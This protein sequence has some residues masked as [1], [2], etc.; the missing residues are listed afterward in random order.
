MMKR[1][2]WGKLNKKKGKIDFDEDDKGKIVI[3]EDGK[4][5]V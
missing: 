1:Y 3:K 4:G 2:V 5:N